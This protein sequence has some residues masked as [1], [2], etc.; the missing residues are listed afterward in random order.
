MLAAF[1]GQLRNLR[2]SIG[3][4]GSANHVLAV[5]FLARAGVIEQKS[6]TLLPLTPQESPAKLRNGNIDAAVLMGTWETPA[7]RQ[8]LIAKKIDLMGIRKADAFVAWY[9]FLN[10]LVL[11]TEV[12]NMA[13]KRCTDFGLR[14]K[15]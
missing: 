11:P 3:A 2:M 9:P 6:A 4:E 14:L 1:F 13:P 12:A 7:V 5:E 10:K 15:A 8:L